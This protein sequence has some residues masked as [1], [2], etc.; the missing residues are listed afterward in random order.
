MEW[1]QPTLVLRCRVGAVLEEKSYKTKMT[2]F[3]SLVERSRT[4][5]VLRCRVGAVLNEEP[6]E[7]KMTT[8]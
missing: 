5:L 8:S 3:A 7:I 4:S 6:C 2:H 1:G